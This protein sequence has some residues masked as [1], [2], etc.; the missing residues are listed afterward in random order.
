MSTC[1][2][3]SASTWLFMTSCSGRCLHVI[4]SQAFCLSA[5]AAQKWYVSSAAAAHGSGKFPREAVH[6]RHNVVV[7]YLD[8]ATAVDSG[9]R[10]CGDVG[11]DADGQ[12]AGERQRSTGREG[13]QAPIPVAAAKKRAGWASQERGGASCQVFSVVTTLWASFTWTSLVRSVCR[14]DP[15]AQ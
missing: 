2:G 8:P 12:C 3:A 10:L 4:G 7:T 15:E 9:G 11:H 6:R 14:C 13:G 1:H 5:A